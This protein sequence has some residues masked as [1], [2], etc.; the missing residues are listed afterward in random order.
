MLP[1]EVHGGEPDH[2]FPTG[3]QAPTMDTDPPVT[4][5]YVW[6]SSG[7]RV[8]SAALE[9]NKSLAT[10][11]TLFPSDHMAVVADLVISP[12][13]TATSAAS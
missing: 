3:L 13:S 2:T 5:D 8:V 1:Q 4:T 12:T 11:A 6:V 10:D 7:V 9:A